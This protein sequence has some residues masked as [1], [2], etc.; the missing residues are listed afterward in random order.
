MA[1][2]RVAKTLTSVGS[3]IFSPAMQR[4][5]ASLLSQAY[6]KPVE[7]RLT[8]LARPHLDSSILASVITQQL[9]DRRNPPRRVTRNAVWRVPLPEAS[10]VPSMAE[11]AAVAVRELKRKPALRSV[12]RQRTSVAKV[13]AELRLKRVSS[14]SV[15][16]AGRLG[17]RMTANRAEGKVARKGL[18]S[19]GPGYLVRGVRPIHAQYTVKAGKRRVGAFGVK[20][21]VGHS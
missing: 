2:S 15:E 7:L 16:T 6:G 21:R 11:H 10:Q 8:K 18:T 19:K 4:P 1:G 12:G 3:D 17:K 14:L 5:L 9:R 20:V 13:L